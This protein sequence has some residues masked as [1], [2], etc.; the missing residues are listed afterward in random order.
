MA[1]E[2]IDLDGLTTFCS[3][4]PGPSLAWLVFRVGCVDETLPTRGIT[5]LTAGLAIEGLDSGGAAYGATSFGS[6]TSF[7]ADGTESQVQSILRH[8]WAHLASPSAAL[9]EEA[10]KRQIRY[11]GFRSASGDDQLLALR[12]GPRGAGLSGQPE[13]GL[14]HVDAEAVVAWRWRYFTPLNAA[15]ALRNV[16]PDDLRLPSVEPGVWHPAPGPGPARLELPAWSDDG[17]EEVAVA[18]VQPADGASDAFTAAAVRRTREKLG[19][20]HRVELSPIRLWPG[21]DHAAIHCTAPG[22]SGARVR[23]VLMGVLDELASAGPDETE[24]AAR[25]ARLR[26]WRDDPE[27][28][29]TRLES[30]AHLHVL[31]PEGRVRDVMDEPEPPSVQDAAQA[32]RDLLATAIYLVPSGLA[33]PAPGR[34]VPRSS[35]DTVSGTSYEYGGPK[36]SGSLVVGTEGV[37]MALED[38]RVTILYDRCES[39][40]QWPDGTIDL[41]GSDGFGMQ[42]RP[43]EWNRGDSAVAEIA[44]H[45]ADRLIVLRPPPDA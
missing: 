41:Y 26:E 17:M 12:Y 2:R 32:A 34:R 5:Q 16:A 6:T 23:D 31:D 22:D 19:D 27:T 28:E 33:L 44:R 14:H 29:L 4:G 25:H 21:L 1:I 13:V 40:S 39:A 30:V 7:M 15:L 36:R 42:V 38:R 37:T 9:L 11:S 3:E 10:R 24:I 18:S 45:V 43:H 8:V 35:T 20:D